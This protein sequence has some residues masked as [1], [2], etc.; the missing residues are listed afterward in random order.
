MKNLSNRKVRLSGY[1]VELHLKSTEYKSQDD[2]QKQADEIS[3]TPTDDV[4][5]EVEG[6]DFQ[7]LKSRFSELSHSLDRFRNDLVQK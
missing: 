4:E 6:F 2:S 1:G 7:I 3:A 5:M